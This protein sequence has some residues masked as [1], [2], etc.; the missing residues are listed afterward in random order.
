MVWFSIECYF[1]LAGF[2]PCCLQLMAFFT[3]PEQYVFVFSN[4]LTGNKH[5]SMQLSRTLSGLTNLLFNRRYAKT[6][7]Q[8]IYHPSILHFLFLL[9]CNALSLVYGY[10]ALLK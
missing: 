3:S 9:V 10:T 7:T 6:N 8:K 1:M 2:R 5:V 4:F